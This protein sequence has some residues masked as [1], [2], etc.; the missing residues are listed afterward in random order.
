MY[1]RVY[2]TVGFKAPDFTLKDENDRDISLDTFRKGRKTVL[3]FVRGV[4]DAHTRE[5]IDYLKDD[6]ERFQF[7]GADVLV[8]SP[9]NVQFNRKMHDN[10]RL[11]FHILSDQRCDIIRQYGIYNEYDKLTGPAIFV[12]NEAGVVVFMSVGKNPWDIME[13]E[14]IIKALEGDTQTPPGW[15]EQ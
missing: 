2:V 15:P 5:Q 6:F 3:A 9:G 11:P 12:L 13:D 8:V 4:D 10:H 14:E 1:E 7:H